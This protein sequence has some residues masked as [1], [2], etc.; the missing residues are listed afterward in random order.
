MTTETKATTIT[1]QI[2]TTTVTYVIAAT[3]APAAYDGF[4]TFTLTSMGAD[5]RGKALRLVLIRQ[6]HLQWQTMRYSSALEGWTVEA[7]RYDYFD[8]AC[9][10]VEG[11]LWERLQH[12]P[13]NGGLC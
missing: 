13:V 6:E 5:D 7:G 8:P 4:G 9:L 2:G 10:D 1:V 3:T 12:G 11:L